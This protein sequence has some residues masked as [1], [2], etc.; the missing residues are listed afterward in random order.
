[1]IV[2]QGAFTEGGFVVWGEAPADTQA[3]PSRRKRPGTKAAAPRTSPF[4]AGAARLVEALSEGIAGLDLGPG[5]AAERVVWL[6]TTD[7]GPVASSN[8]VGDSPAAGTKTVIAPW[9]VAGLALSAEQAVELLATCV[10]RTTMAA[11]VV[12]GSTLS[13]WASALRFAGALVARQQYVPGLSRTGKGH[14]ARWEPVV[15]GSDAERLAALARAMPPACRA[16][17]DLGGSP[18]ESPAAA[19]LRSFLGEA[20][21]QLVRSARPGPAAV[22]LPLPA[23]LRAR[24]RGKAKARARPTGKTGPSA[25]FASVHDAW[26]D[27][28]KNGQGL[29]EGDPAELDRLEAQV[30]QWHRPIRLT[31]DAPV[32]LC[33]RLEEPEV[34]DDG[35]GKPV[36]VVSGDWSVRYLLQAADEPSLLVPVAGLKASRG[37]AADLFKRGRDG[38]EPREYLLAALGQASALCPGVEQSLK[39]RSP[40]GFTLDAGGAH[41]FL[42][43]HASL[44]EQAGFGVLLPAWWSR[45]GTTLRLSAKAAV[46]SPSMSSRSGLS[47]DDVLT[48]RWQVALGD[49]TLSFDELNALAKLKTPLVRVRGR[50]VQLSTEEINAALAFW[51]SRGKDEIT[52]RQAVH[53][54]LGAATPPGGLA[55]EGVEASGWV[56]DLLE[57]LG[58]G[59]GPEPLE[60]P[61]GFKGTLRPYQERGFAWLEFLTRWGLG[62]CLADDMGLGK[63]VQTLALLQRR[64]EASPAKSRRPTLLVCPTSV[65]G[66]WAREASRF[67]PGLPVLVHHGSGRAKGRSFKASANKHALVLSSYALLHRDFDA[68]AT[69]PWAGLILDEAQ[70]IKNPE[71]KQA[72]ASRALEAGFRVALTGTP[73]ENH[74][75]DLW[76]LMEFLNPGWLG[77]R[78]EF[79]RSFHVPIQVNQDEEASA[80]LRKLTGPFVLRRLKTDRTV[81]ADLPDKNEMTVYCTLTREQASLY[82]AVVREASDDLE[83]A[84]GIRRKGVVLATLSKL[85][86][87]CNHPAQFL[88][89]NSPVPGRSG[90]LARLTEMLEEALAEG[91][92]ALIFSQFAEMGAILVRHLQETFGED[93]LFLHGAVP[94]A[95]RDAMV[96]RFQK[97]ERG[98]PRL[99]VLSLKAGGTG[100]NL[101]RANRVFHYDRW[102]NPAVENQATDRAFRIGQ[103]RAVQ[104]HKFVCAGT[105]EEAIDAVIARKQEVAGRIVGAGEDWLTKLSTEELKNVITLR[106]DALAE[107]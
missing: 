69:V 43:R 85:K 4:D 100:L 94:K 97:A 89:D 44:L 2:L 56:A 33:F 84:D 6:P 59:G 79:K 62:A 51:K 1:M 71:T 61:K 19:V 75:G 25:R 102:W 70:N 47:L 101:T 65:V 86:Q 105:M 82:E 55:F 66:N 26:L 68:L 15:I 58:A 12:V 20:V 3:V 18:P 42:T 36:S 48:F 35:D 90:K 93:V 9:K 23:M 32:R 7:R 27:A 21:D 24:A 88:R 31:A 99:F 5:Q 53:M 74:V 57:Q 39:K 30:R 50:W 37:A 64:W 14:L 17:G 80:R 104:V 78:A 81:I 72:R 87:V 92:R 22:P 76:S 46:K 60:P 11:G 83:S 52:A 49:Q 41:E 45:K 29:V 8:L 63:T 34:D 38:F 16:L 40:E 96:E 54:A 106:R 91:D 13:F 10:G 103:T 67:T 98:G 28:L 107:E 95:K 77:N 73:V